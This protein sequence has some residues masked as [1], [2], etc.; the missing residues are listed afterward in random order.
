MTEV[1]A[2]ITGVERLEWITFP[3]TSPGDDCVTV[4]IWL[5]GICGTD[6]ASFRTGH[7][8]S[9]ATCGHEWVGTVSAVGSGVSSLAEGDRVVIGSV[10]ACGTC[11]ACQRGHGDACRAASAVVR[12]LDPLAPPHGGFAKS[13]NV[14]AARLVR[15][16]PGLSDEEAAQ[17]EPA[18][19]ALHGIRRS[20]IE[21][22]ATVVVQGM[23]PIGLI[24]AQFARAAGAGDVL[25]IE[26]LESRRRLALDLGATEALTPEKALGAV[27]DRTGGLGADVVVECSG[28]PQL[29]QTAA[30]LARL[31]GVVSLLSFVAAP[32]TV[33]AARWLSKELTI[34]ASIAFSRDDVGRAMSFMAEGRVEATR[35][36][37]RTVPLAE[38]EQTLRALASGSPDDVKVLVDPRA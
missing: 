14:E 29:L 37:S 34:V 17:A 22:G 9:P 16:H 21:P 27:L 6:I 5:C 19:V 15:A 35:L 25:V 12:G 4:D 36:H 20:R 2:L 24:A 31:S 18:S 3:A 8:H 28:V 23:G 13:I 33:N 10:P 26:P 11:P 38:L 7:L 1:A 32:A 30:D